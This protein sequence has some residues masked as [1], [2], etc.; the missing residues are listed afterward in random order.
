MSLVSVLVFSDDIALME[1]E[2]LKME[3]IYLDLSSNMTRNPSLLRKNL[4]GLAQKYSLRLQPLPRSW[5]A[6]RLSSQ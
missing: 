6:S 5:H 3:S 4:A 2:A 1:R